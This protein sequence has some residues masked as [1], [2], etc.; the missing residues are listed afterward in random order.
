MR[1]LCL[2]RFFL[3]AHHLASLQPYGAVRAI[4]EVFLVFL[5]LGLTSFGG[6]IAHIGYF[7]RE[8][9]ERKH[10]LDEAAFAQLLAI[11]QFLPGPASSQLGF[12]IGLA[13]AGLGG[14]LAAFLGFTLP[15]ALA[16]LAF[17]IYAPAVDSQVMAV[18]VHGLKLVAVVVV[19]HGLWGMARTLTPDARRIAIAAAA[20]VLVLASGHAAMQLGAIALGAVLGMLWCRPAMHVEA[21]EAPLRYPRGLGWAAGG[22]AL[23]LLIFALVWPLQTSPSL[24]GLAAA[25]YRAG[26]LVFGGGHVV[27]PLLQA[28]L[29]DTGWM[30]SEQFLAGYG[31]AQAVPGPMFSLAVYLGASLPLQISPWLVGLLALAAVFLPGFLLLLAALPL[32]H[33]WMQRPW[34]ARS[35]AGINAAVV[36]LLTAAFWNPVLREGIGSGWDVAIA[37][38]GFIALLRLRLPILGLLAWCLLGAWM[39]WWLAQ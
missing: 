17:A 27:L 29:V 30:G 5:R 12:G 25:M 36:G 19:A 11:C 21:A 1:D 3:S 8:F 16:M 23:L 6:P 34:A 14:A 15:S 28:Q 4:S 7:R 32:W 24:G 26:A 22:M 9:V 38:F 10:W 35:L 20:C 37:V 31:A 13:R 33:G 39:Q 18:A 2:R